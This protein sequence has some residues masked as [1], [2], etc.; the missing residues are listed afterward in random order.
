MQDC[1]ESETKAVFI[2]SSALSGSISTE[3]ENIVRT[4]DFEHCTVVTSI[5]PALQEF[6]GSYANTQAKNSSGN[7]SRNLKIWMGNDVSIE[8]LKIF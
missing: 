1:L 5:S 7:F 2:I 6:I 4:N 3:I 8:A